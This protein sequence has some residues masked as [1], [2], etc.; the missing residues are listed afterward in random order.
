[1]QNNLNKVPSVY[2]L[3]HTIKKRA[4]PLS[5]QQINGEILQHLHVFTTV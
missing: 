5:F 1:M 2:F 3:S 4:T